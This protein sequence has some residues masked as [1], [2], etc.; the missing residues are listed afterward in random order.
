MENDSQHGPCFILKYLHE[1][2][3]SECIYF[4]VHYSDWS[5][6]FVGLL[7]KKRNESKLYSDLGENNIVLLVISIQFKT[8]TLIKVC[9]CILN[10]YGSVEALSDILPFTNPRQKVVI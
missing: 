5:T 8:A 10:D 3:Q 2:L 9:N 6:E 7:V 4:C 1:S